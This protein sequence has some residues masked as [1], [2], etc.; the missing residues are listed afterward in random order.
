LGVS[1]PFAAKLVRPYVRAELPGWG[2]VL[3]AVGVK[4]NGRWSGAGWATVPSKWHGHALRLNVAN[5]S[6]R[7]A[8]FL[9]RHVNLGVQL[10]MIAGCRKGEH[11]VDIG[12]NIGLM[13]LLMAG[14]VGAMG[15]VAA[16]EPNPKVFE[17]LRGHVESNGLSQVSLHACALAD[18]PGELTL[19][20]IT[21]H[22]GLGTLRELTS[23]E[24]GSV[25]ATYSV[26][27]RVCDEVLYEAGVRP[28]FIKID[29]EGY[30]CKVLRGL[31]RTLREVGP[32]VLCEA[33]EKYLLRAGDSLNALRE[34]MESA[35]Y[36]GFW[37]NVRRSGGGHALWLVPLEASHVVKGV[38]NAL[39]LKPEHRERYSAA[40]QA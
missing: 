40:L 8:Y 29:V 7:Y 32:I 13:T 31:T 9:G 39:W 30:E 26:P 20:V 25:S 23:A 28:A 16:F 19:S 21:E 18:Q 37:L 35:G 27:V 33:E 10:A 24:K 38:D 36:T 4:D 14:A 17:R 2:R 5:W 11:A 1:V 22:E 3:D 15:R 12:A 34:I 6:D